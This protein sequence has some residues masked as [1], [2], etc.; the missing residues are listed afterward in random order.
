MRFWDS[1]A[2]VPLCVEQPASA[3]ARTQVQDDPDIAAWWASPVECWSAFA[4]LRR[5]GHIDLD[6]EEAARSRLRALQESW[7][8]IRPSED[9]R[10]QTAR[11]LR[12]HPLRAH[13]ALQLAAALT[14]AG[15]S[16]SG[17]IVAFDRILREA[18][19]LEGLTLLP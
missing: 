19:R 7:S 1:S 17:K 10:I 3:A 18:A 16:P 6:G 2:I 11:L 14:W 12:L 8:E 13:D 4:R 9:I 15:S 5:E